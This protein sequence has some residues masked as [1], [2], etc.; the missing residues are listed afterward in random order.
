MDKFIEWFTKRKLFGISLAFSVIFFSYIFLFYKK[1]FSNCYSTQSFLCVDVLN[2]ISLILMYFVP[3]FILSTILLLIRDQVFISWRKTIPIYLAFYLLILFIT[4]WSA[5]DVFLKIQKDLFVLYF[6]VIYVV[7]S[8]I[9]IV[10]KSL[11]KQ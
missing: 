11:K 3:L 9:L 6:S 2:Y 1:L 8:L 5:G 7:Y 10:Y 4:P